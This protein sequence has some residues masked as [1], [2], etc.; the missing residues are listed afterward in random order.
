MSQVPPEPYVSSRR[1]G[2]A[3][4]TV[5]NEG[6]LPLSLDSIFPPEQAAYLRANGEVDANDRLVSDQLVILIQTGD[7]AIV[8]DPAYDDATSPWNTRFAAKWPGLQRTPGLAAGLARVGVR[9]EEITH[10]L[11]TH[12]HEDHFA[13]VAAERDGTIDVRFPNARHLIG[14]QDWDGNPRR[15][16]PES[17]LATRLG[18][19][20]ARG[21]LELVDG[22]IE[23]APGV[24]MLH[25]PGE[26]PGHSIVRLDADGERFYAVGD[27]FH[28]ASEVTHLDWVSPWADPAVM[29]GSRE[30]LLA[31][32]VPAV[33]T[34]VFTHERFPA[35]GRITPAEAGYRW[36]RT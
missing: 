10:V 11:I 35:W 31:E 13:G 4:V 26:T 28:H 17:P 32:A 34:I 12:A 18:A 22:D 29:R 30:R 14:R 21:L 2:N 33:A 5:I 6:H 1:F 3:T 7:A 19:V 15:D 24:T 27:L 20:E 36:Q 16:D 9:P 8:I 25:A 23:V